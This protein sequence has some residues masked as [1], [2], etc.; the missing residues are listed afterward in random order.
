MAKFKS[1][2]KKA[3]SSLWG[4]RS[5]VAILA[6][7]V[8]VLTWGVWSASRQS[9]GVELTSAEVEQLAVGQQVYAE[10]CASCHGENL[11]GQPDWKIPNDDGT[12]KAPPHNEDGHTWH[13][14]DAYLL[15][16]IRYGTQSLDALT[17]SQ[18]NMP[19]YDTILTDEEIDSVLAYIQST[20]PP[21]I[22]E[23]QAQR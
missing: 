13:H 17:Q 3:S 19:A 20:W 7:L 2:K 23:M 9:A 21:R 4:P 22:Q 1:K 18:S 10:N 12:M 5:W 15:D 14:S 16:R 6:G 11:E 8:L